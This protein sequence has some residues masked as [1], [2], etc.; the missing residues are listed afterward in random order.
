MTLPHACVSTAVRPWRALWV[1]TCAMLALC[2]LW[3]PVQAAAVGAPLALKPGMQVVDAWS[4]IGVLAD[5]SHQLSVSEVLRQPGTFQPP[6]HSGGSLGVRKEA[7]WLRIPLTVVEAPRS[8]W[9][10]NIDYSSLLEVDIYLTHGG[11]VLQHAPLGYL[12]P[13]G[14]SSAGSRTPAMALNLEPGKSYEVLI[15]VRTLGPLILPITLSE[16][17]YRMERAL[18]EQM[19]QGLL[20]GLALWLLLYS[21]TQ[22]A[23]QRDRL[24]AYYAMVVLGSTLFSLQFFGIGAQFLWPGNVWMEG[25]G[26]IAGGLLALTGSFLFLEHALGDG[27][28]RSRYARSMRAGAA[29]AAVAAVAFVMD[30]LSVRAATALMSLLGVL[31]TVL[32]MPVALRRARRAE[33]IGTTLLVAWTAYGVAAGVM[34]A[35]VRGWLPVNFWTLHSFQIGATLDMLLFLRVLGLRAQATQAAAQIALNERDTMHSLAHT[36]S[37]TGLH[38]RRGLERALHAALMQREE[39]HTGGRIPH[40]PRRLQTGERLAWT[41]RGGR[42][43]GGRGASLESDTRRHADLVARLGGDEFIVMARNLEAPDQAQALGHQLLHA[44]EQPFE[45]NGLRL[46]VGL[47]IGYALAPLDHDDPQELIRLADAAMYAGKQS[48][49]RTVRRNPGELALSSV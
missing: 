20:N 9:I 2:A 16:T 49:K 38:N 17:P 1:A 37:L 41:R 27:A 6:A 5:D 32:S 46:Q 4:A 13:R 10:V 29:V 28:P 43:A 14:E 48:G 42:A 26:A 36:D 31:P 45:L 21:L 15:R 22:W 40:G 47:T 25:H 7:V 3:V 30:L 39:K 24:F 19:L 8:P 35:L 33:P 12:R 18:R 11:Q 44:F 23:G 34:V